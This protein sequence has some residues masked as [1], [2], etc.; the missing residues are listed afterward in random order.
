M[1]EKAIKDIVIRDLS[2][3]TEESSLLVRLNTLIDFYANLACFYL[4]MNMF[5]KA[6]Y[7]AD[8]FYCAHSMFLDEL[9]KETK[10][11]EKELKISENIMKN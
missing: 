8:L 10:E 11:L 3:I 7:Y 6:K 4:C 5:E 1:E 9:E 2:Q